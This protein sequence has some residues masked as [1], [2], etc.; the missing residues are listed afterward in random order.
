MLTHEVDD[1][2]AAVALLDVTER[3]RR[4]LRSP[5]AAA[6]QGGEDSAI[7]EVL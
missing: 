4:H 2:P 7:T 3:Q 1:A 5:E 6:E